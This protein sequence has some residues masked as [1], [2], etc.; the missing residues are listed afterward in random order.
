MSRA[1]LIAGRCCCEM[2]GRVR[3]EY[4]EALFSF[5]LMEINKT[6]IGISAW[7]SNQI[8]VKQWDAIT[9]PYPNVRGGLVKPAIGVGTNE[10]KKMGVTYLSISQSQ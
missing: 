3:V 8:N 6:S 5:L 1:L 7:I 10:I 9:H 2:H 4:L